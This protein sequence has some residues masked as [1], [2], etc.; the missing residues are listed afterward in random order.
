MRNQSLIPSTQRRARRSHSTYVAGGSLIM[1]RAGIVGPEPADGSIC[2]Y[3]SFETAVHSTWNNSGSCRC[4]GSRGRWYGFHHPCWVGCLNIHEYRRHRQKWAH[5][6]TRSRSLQQD[7]SREAAKKGSTCELAVCQ[8]WSRRRH[9]I[10]GCSCWES[11]DFLWYYSAVTHSG[12]C[13]SELTAR[14]HCFLTRL[15]NAEPLDTPLLAC[16]C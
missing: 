9:I 3:A 1:Q 4:E 14:T 7:E 15:L 10:A 2:M 6:W 12:S 5:G 13:G 16:A 11:M 8:G